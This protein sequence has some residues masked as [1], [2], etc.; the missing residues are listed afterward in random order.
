MK[1]ILDS[2]DF[3]LK[4]VEAL[5]KQFQLEE[6]TAEYLQ[7]IITQK[8]KNGSFHFIK[9]DEYLKQ[10][11]DSKDM[12][13]IYYANKNFMKFLDESKSFYYK[14]VFTP[15][16]ALNAGNESWFYS[17]LNELMMTDPRR[18]YF[19][20]NFLSEKK[21]SN[22]KK[23]VQEIFKKYMNRIN[24]DYEQIAFSLYMSHYSFDEDIFS[25]VSYAQIKDIIKSDRKSRLL[26]P[27]WLYGIYKNGTSSEF[28]EYFNSATNL[29]NLDRLNIDQFQIFEFSWPTNDIKREVL[30][31]KLIQI[32]QD[33]DEFSRYL[34]SSLLGNE[35]IRSSFNQSNKKIDTPQFSL[36]RSFYKSSLEDGVGVVF[37]LYNLMKA[38]DLNKLYLWW[39]VL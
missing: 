20:K 17:S 3:N 8:E 27:L 36:S 12:A 37:S 6:T 14:R 13:E 22:Y 28:L 19:E 7:K 25:E 11:Q 5:V 15:L 35:T 34:F 23:M 30:V 29:E 31:S 26:F 10:V 9:L 18:V 32:G 16:I 1:S 4:Q 21:S 38:G 24:V 2:T 33:K 39:L